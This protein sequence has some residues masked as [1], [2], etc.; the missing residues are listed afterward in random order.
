MKIGNRRE[1]RWIGGAASYLS[2]H[3]TPLFFAL[4]AGTT[5]EVE[6]RWND[7]SHSRASGVS[8]RVAIE[9]SAPTAD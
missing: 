1:L 8:G 5:A 7:A 2:G 6:V 3:D 9:P 4:P